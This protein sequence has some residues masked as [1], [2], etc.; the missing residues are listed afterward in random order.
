MNPAQQ[1]L[2]GKEKF[3]SASLWERL[4]GAGTPGSCR[5]VWKRAE[6][7]GGVSYPQFSFVRRDIK[8]L[9]YL[10]QGRKAASHSS[11]G[12]VVQEEF[13]TNERMGPNT[14]ALI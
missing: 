3:L 14:A 1:L 8:F 2:F 9:T 11:Q 10:K 4:E 12:N 5:F 7:L 13:T 6:R